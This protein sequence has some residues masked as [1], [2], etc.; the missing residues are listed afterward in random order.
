MKI[1]HRITLWVAGAGLSAS[2]VF[3]LVIFLVMRNQPLDVMDSQLKAA[4]ASMADQL[5]RVKGPWAN[6]RTVLLVSPRHYWIKVYDMNLRPAYRSDLTE[7]VDLPLYRDKGEEGYMVSVHIPRQR[8]DLQQ[9]D[10]DNVVFRT[11]VIKEDIAGSPYL[12]QIA[13]P[14][15]DLE[16]KNLD[17]LTA[18]SISLA[19]S[20]ALLIGSSYFLAGRIVEPIAVINRLARD[21]NE[22]TLDKRIPPGRSQDEL[23]ELA[24]RLNEMFDRLQLSFDRQKQFVAD[25]SHELKSPIAML[26]LFFD[27]AMQRQDLPEAF[28]EHLDRQGHNVL[29]MGRLVRTLLELSALEIRRSVSMEPFDLVDLTHSVTADFAPL[30]EKENIRLETKM[31]DLLELWGDKEMLRRAF[32]NILDNAVKYTNEAGH[33]GLTVIEV[34]GRVHFGL[35]NT[36]PGISKEDLPSVFDQFY[37]VDKSR[38]TKYG[39]AGL[40]LA[41]VKQIVRLHHG[42]ILIDSVEGAWTR[43]DVYLPK[44][45][46]E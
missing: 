22:N 10:E 8:I 29:R 19:V 2:L 33:I 18:I 37:R 43:V 31:P 41:I 1:R 46:G 20:T 15:E 12:I 7:I 34:Q 24:S 9:D 25:A 36:G 40:G 45:Y 44:H 38:S 23:H 11:R 42:T 14:M 16:E 3:S 27:E 28:R 5:P 39:G 13:R 32:I 26:R 6:E 4:A 21:I 30:M 17:L 35:R